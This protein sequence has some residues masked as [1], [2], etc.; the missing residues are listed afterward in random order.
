MGHV[1]GINRFLST[2]SEI[3]NVV[4]NNLVLMTRW[5]GSF[6]AKPIQAIAFTALAMFGAWPAIFYLAYMAIDS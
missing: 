2:G 6:L 4:F 1:V 5:L 3:E